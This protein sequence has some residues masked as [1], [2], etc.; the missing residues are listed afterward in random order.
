MA[1]AIPATIADRVVRDL[2]ERKPTSMARLG[3]T[4]E[5]VKVEGHWRVRVVK[6]KGPASEGG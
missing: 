5:A 1:C 2:K 3:I 6:V 4:M